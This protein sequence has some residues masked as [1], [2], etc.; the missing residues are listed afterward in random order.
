VI[1]PIVIPFTRTQQGYIVFVVMN[2]T[3]EK[4]GW[5]TPKSK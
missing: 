3:G 1:L 4:Y 5:Q 2:V